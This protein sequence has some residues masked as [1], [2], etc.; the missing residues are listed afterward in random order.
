MGKGDILRLLI[1]SDS[2]NDAE[3]LKNHLRNVGY[4]L[5]DLRIQE[6]D[7]FKTALKSQEWD[8][9]L[10]LLES[11]EVPIANIISILQQKDIPVIMVADEVSTAQRLEAL[12]AGARDIVPSQPDVFLQKV[13]RRELE[14]SKLKR[15]LEICN[16]NLKGLEGRSLVLLRNSRDAIAYIQEGVHV[17]ANLSYLQIFGFSNEEDVIGLTFLDMV[18]SSKRPALKERLRVTKPAGKPLEPL[19]I[20]A[21]RADGTQ[22]PAKIEF[23]QSVLD[24]EPCI[25]VTISNLSIDSLD[26]FSQVLSQVPSQIEVDPMLMMVT[27]EKFFETIPPHLPPPPSLPPLEPASP[28]E[29]IFLRLS[30]ESGSLSLLY[31]PILYLRED[32]PGAYEVLPYFKNPENPNEIR[33]LPERVMQ[34][35]EE[36]VLQTA[37]DRWVLSTALKTLS[38]QVEKSIWLLVSLSQGSVLDKDFPIWLEM[39]TKSFDVPMSSLVLQIRGTLA[40]RNMSRVRDLITQLREMGCNFALSHCLKAEGNDSPLR[41]LEVDYF[42]IDGDLIRNLVNNLGNQTLVR[43]LNGQVHSIGK[44]TIAESVSDANTLSLLW[45]YGVDFI[46]GD[47]LQIPSERMEYEFSSTSLDS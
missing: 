9:V 28:E 29:V 37:V 34:A 40:E 16:S 7:Q 22:F 5:R 3:V 44:R 20:Q 38:E 24:G 11:T 32:S 35:T 12:E 13:V 1:F 36:A 15:E 23:S 33:Y 26:L 43:T 10:F 21:L 14:N 46:Q 25:Q 17:F 8:I 18:P 19:E 41:Q 39:I 4:V 30:L 45:Q 2:W 6:E 42:R 31:Q 47:Y 27:E